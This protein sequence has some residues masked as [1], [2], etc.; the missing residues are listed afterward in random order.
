MQIFHPFAENQ[1]QPCRRELLRRGPWGR[2]LHGHGLRSFAPCLNR[3][4]GLRLGRKCRFEGRSGVL[5]RGLSAKLVA[6]LIH[7]PVGSLDPNPIELAL[8]FLSLGTGVLHRIQVFSARSAWQKGTA[9]RSRFVLSGALF[10]L[11]TLTNNPR[12]YCRERILPDCLKTRTGRPGH[13]NLHRFI[14][15]RNEKILLFAQHAKHL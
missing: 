8:G 11:L 3:H 14:G 13:R 7:G 5:P 9:A 2:D 15:L 1:G 10:L 6:T 4:M 12:A